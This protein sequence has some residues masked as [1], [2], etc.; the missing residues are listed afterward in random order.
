[1]A[2]KCKFI[3]FH[4]GNKKI[5][6]K[7]F[8]LNGDQVSF[9]NTLPDLFVS[10]QVTKEVKIEKLSPEWRPSVFSK[11]SAIFIHIGHKRK[12]N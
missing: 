5:K 9:Q 4:T 7:G 3:C 8:H 6:L 2:T 12:E 11:H 10:G 1:M